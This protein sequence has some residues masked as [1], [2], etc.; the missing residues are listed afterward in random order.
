MYDDYHALGFEPLAINLWEN[1]NTVKSYA[2]QYTYSFLRDGG[3]AWS[4]YNINGSIPVN[5]VIDTSGIVQYGAVG[6][7]ESVIRAY[8]EYL[9][10]P[11]G[12]AEKNPE[13]IVTSMSAV[14]NPTND[15]ARVLFT[16][17]R[18]ENVSVRVYSSSGKLVK[19]LLQGRTNAGV[20][21]ASWNL[22]DDH[23]SRVA[24]GLYFY[25]LVTG[26]AVERVSV[27]VVR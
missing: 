17:S 3:A 27:S 24:N 5:Y 19:T 25:E 8:I 2:R 11:T 9:L 15:P 12:V 4:L 13:K 20:S 14:P 26:N 18:P 23:G 21:Y 1:M 22:Q 10:P 6:F 16:L 7:D